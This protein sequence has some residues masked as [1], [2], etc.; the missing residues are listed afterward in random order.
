MADEFGTVSTYPRLDLTLTF[1][2][3]SIKPGNGLP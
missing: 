2:T 1:S 3:L